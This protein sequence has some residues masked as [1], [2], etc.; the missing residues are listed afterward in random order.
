MFR[1]ID[2]LWLLTPSAV[3]RFKDPKSPSGLFVAYS[4]CFAICDKILTV[5]ARGT[6]TCRNNLIHCDGRLEP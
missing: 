4:F 5:H 3:S 6:S 2:I 1:G